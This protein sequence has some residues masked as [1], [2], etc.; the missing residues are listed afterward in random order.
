MRIVLHAEN[1]LEVTRLLEPEM[2][3]ETLDPEAAYSAL[4]MFATSIAL[5][6]FS[7]LY[8][9]AATVG[10]NPADIALRVRWEYATGENRIA[11]IDLAIDWPGLPESR[12]AAAERAAALCTLHKTLEHSPRVA[13]RLQIPEATA[14]QRPHR[15]KHQ[16]APPAPES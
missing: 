1:D 13:T 10:A 11:D 6:S 7:M 4:Q 16:P 5:C 2:I 3:V 8:G 15:H 12:R 9:Y 14:E